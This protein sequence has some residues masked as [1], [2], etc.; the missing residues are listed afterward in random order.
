MK[1]ICSFFLLS[2]LLIP[3]SLSENDPFEFQVVPGFEELDDVPET[4]FFEGSDQPVNTLRKKKPPNKSSRLFFNRQR[5]R[6]LAEDSHQESNDDRVNWTILKSV[7]P[8][9]RKLPWQ[10][11]VAKIKTALT[12][13]VD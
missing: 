4:V 5:K 12:A 3:E 2:V 11:I 6:P 8:Q 13:R 9:I 10:W 7:L 1:L